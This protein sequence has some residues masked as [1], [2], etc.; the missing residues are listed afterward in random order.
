M[1]YRVY[2][3]PSGVPILSQ[4]NP[5]RALPSNLFN[6]H[7]NIII[8]STPRFSNQSLYFRVPHQSLVCI[9]VPYHSCHVP[10][11]SRPRWSD[12]TNNVGRGV[13]IMKLLIMQFSPASYSYYFFLLCTNS[14]PNDLSSKNLS[15]CSSLN[16]RGHVPRTFKTAGKII[17][18]NLY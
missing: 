17:L 12:H 9:S 15:L 18:C 11:Q 3:S 14:L 10:H 1:H 13:E 16:M 2:S 4:M 6:I 7:L 5:D 8:P